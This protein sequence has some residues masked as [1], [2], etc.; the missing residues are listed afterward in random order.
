MNI[1]NE[2]FQ[3]Q[4]LKY[5]EF[6]S[7]LVPTIER[8]LFIGVRVPE[9]R[10]FA[11]ELVKKNIYLDFLYDLPHKYY[12]EN[13]LHSLILSELKDYEMCIELIDKFLKY[14]D[15]WA[16]CDILSPKNFKK[17]KKKLIEKIKSWSVSDYV[18]TCRFGIGM[19]MTHYLD[20]DF[21]EEYLEIPSRIHSEEYYVNMMIAWFFATALAKKWNETIVYVENKKLDSWVNNK[22]IQKACESLRI[23]NEQKNYLKLLKIK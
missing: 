4:D 3:L 15:N 17:N 13:M 16:V 14:I 20:E 11:K 19:L 18:Y 8:D 10:K 2:L 12:D 22:T 6:Q 9:L 21:E 1:V 5:A 23:T 7:K